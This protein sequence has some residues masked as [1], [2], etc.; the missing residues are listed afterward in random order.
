MKDIQRIIGLDSMGS[1][2]YSMKHLVEKGAV[3]KDTST[4]MPLYYPLEE[5]NQGQVKE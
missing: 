3:R 2:M 5:T 4:A 1:V